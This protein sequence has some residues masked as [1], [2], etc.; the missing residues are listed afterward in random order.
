MM[1]R[2]I[3]KPSYTYKNMG[4]KVN[5][6]LVLLFLILFLFSFSFVSAGLGTYAK[7]D[8]IPIRVLAN[9]SNVDLIE[10]SSG[11]NLYFINSSMTL[12]GGQ[13]FN[14]SFCTNSSMPLGSYSYSWNNYCVDCSNGD[15]GNS[16]ELGNDSTKV[17]STQGLMII[18]QIGI[19]FLFIAVAFGFTKEKWKIRTFFF[20]AALMMGVITLNSIRIIS[21]VSNNLYSMGN[22]GFIL[23]IVILS[24][25]VAYMLVYYT[26]EVFKYFKEKR[27]MRWEVSQDAN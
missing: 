25:M 7:G 16:F 1:V 8:C 5:K 18:S 21:G 27:R 14:Y 9:C 17:N 24:F 13:T 19:I 20:I 12:L 10:I 22:V 2:K 6:S 26:I 3:Y 4:N 23:G 11:N 15:C